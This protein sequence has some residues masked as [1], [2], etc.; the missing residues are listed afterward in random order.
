MY[1]VSCRPFLRPHRSFHHCTHRPHDSSEINT[2]HGSWL[3]FI[4]LDALL[5]L[6]GATFDYFSLE[7]LHRLATQCDMLRTRRI[8]QSAIVR[9][10]RTI[11]QHARRFR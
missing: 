6:Y 11:Q 1:A 4:Q 3:L 9:P 7:L 10:T 2:H 8:G 5:A